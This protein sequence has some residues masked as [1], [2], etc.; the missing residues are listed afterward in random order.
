MID[1]IKSSLPGNIIDYY[2]FPAKITGK[3]WKE[4]TIASLLKDIKY[5]EENYQKECEGSAGRTKWVSD[6]RAS[7]EEC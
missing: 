6:L 5:H 4:K 1:Q 3:E 7:L 2:H